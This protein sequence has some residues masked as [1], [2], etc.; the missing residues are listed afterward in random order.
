MN[1]IENDARSG[2]LGVAEQK[3]IELTQ[4]QREATLKAALD[5]QVSY[6]AQQKA[7]EEMQVRVSAVQLANQ[8]NPGC[9]T[10]FLLDAATKIEA[11][12]TGRKETSHVQ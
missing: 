9:S 2:A 8:N 6:E 5:Q 11:Y 4:E 1:S 7:R 10:E 12:L 3:C